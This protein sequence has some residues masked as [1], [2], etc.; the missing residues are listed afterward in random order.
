VQ[1]PFNLNLIKCRQNVGCKNKVH[2]KSDSDSDSDLQTDIDT[3]QELKWVENIMNCIADCLYKQCVEQGCMKFKIYG[4][5]PHRGFV[6]ALFNYTSG[7]NMRPIYN[8]I[9]IIGF[10]FDPEKLLKL[11]FFYG[12]SIYQQ[13]FYS[14][15]VGLL[16]R[17]CHE[18]FGIPSYAVARFFPKKDPKMFLAKPENYLNIKNAADIYAENEDYYTAIE[19]HKQAMELIPDNHQKYLYQKYVEKLN[20]YYYKN[21]TSILFTATVSFGLVRNLLT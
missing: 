14:N 7:R 6:N 11:R 18:M 16:C 17:Y 9:D 15:D 1:N 2:S 20:D 8:W 3:M 21:G 5:Q 10:E 4:S 12:D 13:G 19:Y